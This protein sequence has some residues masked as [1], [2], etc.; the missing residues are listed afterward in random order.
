[1]RTLA[2]VADASTKS[3]DS[4]RKTGAARRTIQRLT[5]NT[6]GDVYEQEADRVAHAVMRSPASRPARACPCGGGCPTCAAKRS[7]QH[8]AFRLHRASGGQGIQPVAAPPLVDNVL[9]QPGQP[10][11][12]TTRHSFEERFGRDFS[13][14]RVHTGLAAA[15]SAQAIDAQAYTAQD[16]IVFGD[17]GLSPGSDHA[18]F[19]LA[20]ELTHV[21][22]QT[23]A[24]DLRNGHEPVA[25]APHDRVQRQPQARPTSENV[26]GF[27][28]TRSMCGCRAELREDIDWANTAAATYA[29]CDVP[30][31]T[32]SVAVEACFDAAHPGGGA[33]EATTDPSGTMTLPPPSNDPCQRIHNQATFVHE[34]MHSRHADAIARARGTAFFREWQ[35]LKGDP[36]R[37]T[38]LRA[39][40][41]T[42]VAA[43]SAQWVNGHD[44][45]QDEVNSHRWERRFMEDVNAALN[46][47]C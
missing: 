2:H 28:V 39:T 33:P 17:P 41:P 22:Q 19:L 30:A 7:D 42:E 35:R 16:H 20:H 12:S 43:F 26:W 40:F 24:G 23:G 3:P 32:N 31:N 14:V 34:T 46:R 9:A 36:N 29:A 4:D 27:T 38:T 11:D 25:R 45:A 21:V 5:V 1:M 8:E 10:L 18:R 44:W 6:P 47:I 13:G 37:L 15:E